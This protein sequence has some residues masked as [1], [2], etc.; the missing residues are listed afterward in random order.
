MTVFL[1]PAPQPLP[2]TNSEYIF[3]AWQHLD[4]GDHDGASKA[5]SQA[6]APDSL[7]PEP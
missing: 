4:E 3:Q 1:L 6:H 2:R 5:R 7:D